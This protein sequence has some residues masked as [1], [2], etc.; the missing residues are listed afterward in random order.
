MKPWNRTTV[1]TKGCLFDDAR[2]AQLI[3]WPELT[4]AMKTT[5]TSLE[6]ILLRCCNVHASSYCDAQSP[7]EFRDAG[8]PSF[9]SVQLLIPAKKWLTNAITSFE[10]VQFQL[11]THLNWKCSNL[12]PSPS[13]SEEFLF[14]RKQ[15]SYYRGATIDRCFLIR[16]SGKKVTGRQHE[17][18]AWWVWRV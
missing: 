12:W 8:Y 17:L 16:F 6:F 7:D 4:S 10:S 9:P 5:P 18:Q 14:R 2:R 11:V 15:R 13:S 1:Q 3:K